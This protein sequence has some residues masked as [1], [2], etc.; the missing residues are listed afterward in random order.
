MSQRE[1]R[2]VQVQQSLT[3][4]RDPWLTFGRAVTKRQ[5][6]RVIKCITIDKELGGWSFRITTKAAGILFVLFLLLRI[7]IESVI[8]MLRPS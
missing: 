3:C 5:A 2:G 6:F 7:M 4:F 8:N 1:P